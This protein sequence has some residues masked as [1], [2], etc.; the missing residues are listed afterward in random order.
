MKI[1]AKI[2]FMQ[3]VE[4]TGAWPGIPGVRIRKKSKSL[5]AMKLT[6]ILLVASFL[7]VSAKTAAQA[8]TLS[9]KEMPLIKVF[10]AIKT[11]TGFVFFYDAALLQQAKPVNLTVKNQ[12]LA[13]VLEQVFNDQ[14][15]T[16]T[17]VNKTITV[18]PK[19]AEVK[20]K[21]ITVVNEPPPAN[22]VTGKV[23]DENNQP[24]AGAS[25]VVKGT[26]QGVKA[27]TDG[28]FSIDVNPGSVLVISYVGYEA[29]EIAISNQSTV[30]VRLKS[31]V[32]V[33]EQVVV[34]GYGTQRRKDLTGTISTV[35]GETVA[36]QPGT[37]PVS[38][39]QG[40]VAGLTVSN[41]GRAGASPVVRIRGINSTNSA[42]PVYVVDGILH[43]NID[44]LNPA[45]IETIDVLRDP[46]SI[47]IYGL[48]GANGVIAITSKKAGR[49]ET[50]IN[51]QS[52][53]GIQKVNDKI[54]VA[55]AEGFKK[56]YNAQLAN[57]RAPAFDYTNYTA[58]TNWQN[59]VL[60]D[61]I[62]TSNNLSISNN[63]DKST[64][65]LNIGYTNQD[66]VLRNDNYTR[67]LAR[68]NEEIRFTDKIKVGAEA[69]GYY[70][71]SNAPSASISN[72]LWAAPIVPIQQD[73]N[74]YY[75]MPSFQR[76]QVGNPIAALNRGDG[77]SIDKGFRI[78]GNIFAEIKFARYFTWRSTFYTDLAFNNNRS[79]SRLPYTFINLGE[80]ATPTTTTFDNS[81]RTSVSQIQSESK[82]YQQDHTINFTQSFNN[83]TFTALAGFTSIY[84][85]SS[86]LNAT[87][88]DTSVNINDN[89]DFWYI[90]VSNANNP[91]N[92]DGGGGES[93]IEG[94]FG[95]L[96]YSYA[97]KYLL[98]ATVRRDGSSKFA[99]QNRWGT[100]GSVGLGWIASEEKFFRKFDAINF[101]KFRG[102]WGLTGNANGFA[103]NLYKPGISNASTAIF[104]DNIYSSI[105]ASYIPDPNLHWETVRGL[106][107][108][109]D[110]RTVNNK[111]NFEFTWYNRTTTDILTAVALPNETRSYFTN[112][113]EISN[114]GIEVSL[115]WN[116]KV[117][118][119]FSYGASV[120]FSYNKNE[121]K[122][123]GNNFNF[124]IIGNGGTNLTTTGQSIG[125]FYGYTQTGIYQSSA[126]M[127]KQAT[128]TNSLPGDISYADING[129][130]AITPADRGYIGSPFPPYS[131]GGNFTVGYKG[132]DLDLDVQGM[133]GHKIYTQRRTSTFAVLNYETNRLSAY[134]AP[135][136]SNVEPILD[137]TRGNNFLMST[138]YLE[139]GDYFRIRNLQIGYTFDQKFLAKAG[140]KKARVFINGQNIKTWSKVTGYSPEPII[141]SIL[142]GGADNG[143]Y[144]VPAIY[145]FGLNL[146]F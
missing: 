4:R 42:N 83:H 14:P 95:R 132:F 91:G 37:N 5:L 34:V 92:F 93:A 67:Y 82:R 58:N 46:S 66:G 109:F 88:R 27:G 32:V 100:F 33:I 143:S 81:V 144:P 51:F 6:F 43:D 68:I 74:T 145:S 135:G 72:A 102:A 94:F 101:L 64:T 61:A 130:G 22:I 84:S 121:V 120:N 60:R 54:Q 140:I 78:I 3:P 28:N 24:L 53:V 62:I 146:T 134:T 76:A 123:I 35:K 17:L 44:F 11:Q 99:P 29:Q 71:T 138:Y 118:K 10:E 65:Y 39:L 137:N 13:S 108:G 124:S 141:G 114:K 49:G 79:F 127:A 20:T 31:A 136:T 2:R 131:F 90:G 77:T 126:D 38:S 107:L 98:N 113:G 139:P 117:G 8:V 87:R 40:K 128:F 55:D 89:P 21:E 129:D 97:G 41:T 112:L 25:V 16:W 96:S 30:S 23:T 1:N 85:H 48:R 119:N 104:G 125:Y 47:A 7:Q 106:D 105:Q 45:D 111:L 12:S 80:G 115:G 69:T 57:L 50:R 63:T 103:D 86:Y 9:A 122:S 19:T 116:D 56:L 15:M 18:V 70:W 75:S 110:L 133:A 52:S 142:G 59:L 73:A 36:K 26:T